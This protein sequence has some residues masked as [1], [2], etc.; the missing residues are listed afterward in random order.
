MFIDRQFL[1]VSNSRPIRICYLFRFHR[2]FG[3]WITVCMYAQCMYMYEPAQYI[4]Y[5]ASTIFVS[6][7]P[8][9]LLFQNSLRI[10][11]SSTKW[12]RRKNISLHIHSHR[13]S[14][15][16]LYSTHTHFMYSIHMYTIYSMCCMCCELIFA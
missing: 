6:V 12:V 9:S 16:T 4:I 13:L 11:C 7:I 8:F 5:I 1:I 2:R 15:H 14:P 10:I 3:I